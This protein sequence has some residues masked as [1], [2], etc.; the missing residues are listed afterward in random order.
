MTEYSLRDLIAIC[1]Y[2]HLAY[3]T[4]GGHFLIAINDSQICP[5]CSDPHWCFQ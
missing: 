3:C 5:L 1:E 2:T 4:Q